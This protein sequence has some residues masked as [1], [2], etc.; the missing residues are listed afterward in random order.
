MKMKT[1][2]KQMDGT[3]AGTYCTAMQYEGKPI[4]VDAGK[5]NFSWR[6]EGDRLCRQRAFQI[7]CVRLD[8]RFAGEP[9]N[10]LGQRQG[11]SAAMTHVPYEGAALFS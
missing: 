11:D 3:A 10:G 2:R 9:W 4:G 6:L 7:P 8:G 5:L 1:T